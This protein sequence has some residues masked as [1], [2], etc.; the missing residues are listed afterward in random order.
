MNTSLYFQPGHW[1]LVILPHGGHVQ[2]LAAAGRLAL[3]GPIII[4]D[5]GNRCNVYTLA[6]AVGGRTDVLRRVHLSRAFTCYQVAALLEDTPESLHPVIV[7]DLLSTFYDEAVSVFERR[8]LLNICLA[9]LL[10]LSR[11]AGLLVSAS[12]PKVASPENVALLETLQAGA[13]GVWS[14]A[15]AL[16]VAEPERLF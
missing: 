13:D 6:R 16:P 4:L 8:R 7:L 11:G 5:G 15:P 9:H 12:I 3:R 10:R 14:P 1:G 2:L